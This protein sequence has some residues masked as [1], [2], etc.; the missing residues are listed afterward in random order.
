M[1][2]A[3]CSAPGM[4]THQKGYMSELTIPATGAEASFGG[5]LTGILNNVGTT[6]VDLAKTYGTA[7]IQEKVAE[8]TPAQQTAQR[9]ATSDGGFTKNQLIIGGIA[10][11]LALTALVVSVR[12]R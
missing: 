6:A 4:T 2:G 10:A 5:W 1:P 9:T 11:G 12:N 7:K 8:S 3:G